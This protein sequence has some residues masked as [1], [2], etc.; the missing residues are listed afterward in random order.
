MLNILKS[1]TGKLF[2]LYLFFGFLTSSS[3]LAS[4]KCTQ[5]KKSNNRDVMDTICTNDGASYFINYAPRK[6]TIWF[7]SDKP[8]YRTN[9]K[10]L[11]KNANPEIVGKKSD[12]KFITRNPIVENDRKYVGVTF[13]ERSMRGNGM[14][15]CGGGAEVYFVAIELTEK[16]PIIINQFK[17]E[18]CIEGIDLASSSNN[19][20]SSIFLAKNNR[21]VFRWLNYPD[22]EKPVTGIF[23]FSKNQL[24]THENISPY[25]WKEFE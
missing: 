21:V 1:Q 17:I 15:Q 9:I 25:D 4:P 22:F 11:E 18:S 2:F 24:R 5:T 13:S 19:K 7:D 6:N 14:G 10:L 3:G 8:N 20:G 12:I 16:K 23:D